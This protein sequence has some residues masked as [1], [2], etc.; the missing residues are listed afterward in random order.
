MLG[1]KIWPYMAGTWTCKFYFLV[2]FDV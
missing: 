2:C 1:P